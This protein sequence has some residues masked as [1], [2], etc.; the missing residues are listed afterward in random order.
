M[1]TD[2]ISPSTAARSII[3]SY[4]QSQLQSAGTPAK[5]P[6]ARV[7]LQRRFGENITDG[8]LL[9]KLKA[10]ADAKKAKQAKKDAK[11]EARR[12]FTQNR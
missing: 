1:N 7:R 4:A 3:S 6:T 11:E 12:P 2:Q 5:K 10:K 9:D 8:N